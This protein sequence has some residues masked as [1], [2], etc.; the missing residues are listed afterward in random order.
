MSQSIATNP[1]QTSPY[2]YGNIL[3]ANVTTYQRNPP[4]IGRCLSQAA[5]VGAFVGFLTPVFGLLRH[6]TNGYN[7]LLIFSLPV[8]LAF[9]ICFGV[10]Q[11]AIIWACGHIV[12]H[13]VHPVQRAVLGVVTLATLIAG[14]NF[15][16]AEPSPYRED[17]S[18]IEQA[19]FY[20]VYVGYG[21]LFGLVI[22][23]RLEPVGELLRGTSPP[24]W[25][26]LTG[27]TGLALRVLVIFGLMESVLKLIYELQWEP[28]AEEFSF[29]VLALGH[30][31]AAVV[32]IFVRMPFWLLLPLALIINFP[33]AAFI[34]DVLREQDVALRNIS[35]GYLCVW[36]AFLLTRVRV[37]EA[38]L[39]FIKK[40]LR[41]YLID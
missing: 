21:V 37:P 13:R 12:G 2:R 31:V 4:G 24:Q 26:A 10:I 35:I 39:S 18:A 30:F 19:V 3:F 5:A 7:Y 41:Y 28:S 14:Y 25:L 15:L 23:S 11:G 8:F 22:G 6:P 27:L 20:A 33:I 29:A 38:A 16:F 32:I 17:V 9:G 1:H 36:G 34:T 40:E